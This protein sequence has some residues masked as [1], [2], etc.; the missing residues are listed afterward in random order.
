M[1]PSGCSAL[2]GVNHKFFKKTKWK[3]MNFHDQTAHYREGIQWKPFHQ[4]KL[5]HCQS[6]DWKLF[7]IRQIFPEH[8]TWI[9]PLV[10]SS[11]YVTKSAVPKGAPENNTKILT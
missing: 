4:V 6:T 3:G 9:F 8:K 10:V 1:P 7:W 2:H 5:N 11:V